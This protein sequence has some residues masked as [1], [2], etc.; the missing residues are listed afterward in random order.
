MKRVLVV[1]NDSE[2]FLR[3][4][5]SIV[6]ELVRLGAEVSVMCGGNAISP[7]DIK[8]WAYFPAT[9]ERFR[10]NPVG[11]FLFL[12]KVL[13]HL[14]KLR[15]D[16]LLLIT[17]KPAVYSGLAAVLARLVRCGPKRVLVLMPGLGRLMSPK[18]TIASRTADAWRGITSSAV[19]FLSKRRGF[20]FSFETEHDRS[21]WRQLGLVG[22]RNS[23]VIRG[24]GVDPAVY[25]PAEK[26]MRHGKMRILFASRLITAKGLNLFL[27][28]AKH[29]S[30][31]PDVEFLVA[32]WVEHNDPDRV[33]PD[34]LEGMKEIRFLGEIPSAA[35]VLR[36]CDVVC[37]PT[38]YGEGIPRIL[39]EAAA[40]GLP[41][42]ASN[43]AGCR[44]IVLDG[45][46]GTILP[47]GNEV[48]MLASLNQA[49]LAYLDNPV[50]AKH[51]GAAALKHFR[52]GKFEEKAVMAQFMDLLLPD[53]AVR[54]N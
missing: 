48:Q 37:L 30:G 29:F 40:N 44:E 17:L 28:A 27:G 42:I 39:I 4:R 46:T 53:W 31:R 51:Q 2:Y 26:A 34:R 23:I 13:L 3:H 49:I 21:Y 15:P 1:C 41:S 14:L 10:F 5:L 11:D 16:S 54:T 6:A 32:G 52:D 18:P 24:A 45:V 8:G 38:L 12:M 43:I 33:D 9:I 22:E 7:Q 20:M 19:R 35:E 25:Y 36:D 50:L 47:V